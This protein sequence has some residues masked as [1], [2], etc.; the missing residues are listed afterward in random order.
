[1]RKT[2]RLTGRRQ[3]PQNA[4]DFRLTERDGRKVATLAIVE[5]GATAN[6]PPDSGIRVKLTENKL[7]RILDFG[8]VGHPIFVADVDSDTF[9]APSC[10]VRVVN[11][12]P[13]NNGML[14]GSSRTWTVT[15]SG[16]PDGI[17]LFQPAQIA[18][19]LW[20]LKIGNEDQPI[21]YIDENIP[22]AAQWA[23]SDPTFTAC[24]LP[25]VVT[26]LMHAILDLSDAPEEGWEADWIKWAEIFMP[27][28]PP[29]Y[30]ASAVDQKSWIDELI[31]AFAARHDLA[32]R[33][34]AGLSTT[35]DATA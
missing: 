5:T 10:Q 13:N 32:G 25:A 11:R 20:S 15:S 3:L 7:V 28:S 24:V 34:I 1:M 31:D 35:K 12:S 8:T 17:L 22:D 29:P 27:G 4:F 33:V 2:I 26:E 16:D 23:K 18:P 9:R 6:F 21:L 30:K 19:R 14:L